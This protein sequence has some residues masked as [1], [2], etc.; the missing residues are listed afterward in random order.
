MTNYFPSTHFIFPGFG[1]H[2][3]AIYYYYCIIN[4]A[5]APIMQAVQKKKQGF[6]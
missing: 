5:E 1:V 2:K 4:H 3:H 6:S